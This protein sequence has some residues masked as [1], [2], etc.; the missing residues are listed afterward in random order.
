[1]GSSVSV[2][3]DDISE[4]VQQ[5]TRLL[6]DKPKIRELWMRADENKNGYISLSEFKTMLGE[7]DEDDSI[8]F[9]DF[10]NDEAIRR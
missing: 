9:V 1:M 8:M 10:D 2:G 4:A 6:Q 5:T 7:A 3:L